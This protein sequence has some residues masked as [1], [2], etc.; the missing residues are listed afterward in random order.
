MTICANVI[1]C[2]CAQHPFECVGRMTMAIFTVETS[3][4]DKRVKLPPSVF[5]LQAHCREKEFGILFSFIR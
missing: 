3:F 2:I 1:T 5:K 4:Y